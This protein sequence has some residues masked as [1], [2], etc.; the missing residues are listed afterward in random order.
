MS[1]T[2]THTDVSYVIPVAQKTTAGT[3]QLLNKAAMRH[4]EE[5]GHFPA[6]I[7]ISENRRG[8]WSQS[9]HTVLGHEVEIGFSTCLSTNGVI[10]TP[11]RMTVMKTTRKE[12]AHDTGPGA[13][14]AAS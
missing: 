13:L 9:K 11:P 12:E 10:C 5:K 1:T 3:L 4:K 6:R 7:T 14:S 8:T 2:T